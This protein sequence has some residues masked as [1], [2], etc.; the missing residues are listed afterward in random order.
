MKTLQYLTYPRII[1]MTTSANWISAEK[2]EGKQKYI[3]G[4]KTEKWQSECTGGHAHGKADTKK[5]SATAL[6]RE[7][8]Y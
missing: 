1:D 8:S 3:S 5:V 6:K 7:G 2:A 4:V